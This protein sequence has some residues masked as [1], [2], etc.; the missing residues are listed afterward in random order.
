MECGK[1]KIC[2]TAEW[3]HVFIVDLVEMEYFLATLG[4]AFPVGAL[5]TSEVVF[6]VSRAS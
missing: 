5:K 2:T 1:F 6:E 3:E 4:S